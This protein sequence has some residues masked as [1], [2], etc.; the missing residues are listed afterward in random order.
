[1]SSLLKTTVTG[2]LALLLMSP[3]NINAQHLEKYFRGEKGQ[4]ALR[5]K[6]IYPLEERL[7]LLSEIG[8]SAFNQEGFLALAM[9][10]SPGIVLYDSTGRQLRQVGSMGR[11]PG[12]YAS[13]S[14]IQLL[15]D[16]LYIWDSKLLKFLKYDIKTNTPLLEIQDFRWS[17]QNF[18]VSGDDIYFYNSGRSTGPYIEQYNITENEYG[19][20]FGNRTE[21]HNLLAAYRYAGGIDREN[22]YIYYISPSSLRVYRINTRNGTEKSFIINDS[23]FKVPNVKN[24]REIILSDE[25][26][27][28]TSKMS[29]VVDLFVM[30]KYVLV[31]AHIGEDTYSEQWDAYL[32]TNRKIRMYVLDSDMNYI[33]NFTFSLAADQDL[34]HRIWTANNR[35]LF[36]LST[37]NLFGEENPEDNKAPL[38][39]VH[40]WNIVETVD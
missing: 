3:F 12:E 31:L 8:W 35:Q 10:G 18:S 13:A 40:V 11:G 2:V 34:Q 17:I 21:A 28:I 32:V 1:M 27:K 30:D 7:F 5:L 4:L 25:F 39:Y 14:I 24:A 26:T 19:R 6:T 16:T 38:F 33:D 15:R 22:Q 23:E 20:K 37:Y 36:F 29:R 9:E